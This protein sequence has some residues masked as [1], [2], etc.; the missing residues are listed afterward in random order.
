M[1][2]ASI[3][4]C[5][6]APHPAELLARWNLDPWL[7]LA[8]AVV[9]GAY[10]LGDGRRADRGQL[11]LFVSGW[12]MLVAIF[13]SPLCA[14][15]SA[16]FAA[17]VAHHVVLIGVA[18]PLLVLSLRPRSPLLPVGAAALLHAVV[19][20]FWHAPMPYTAA[21]GSDLLFWVM[22]L[23]LVASAWLFWQGV[24][25]ARSAPTA[26]LMALLGT[27]VQMGLLG[28]L[29][30]FAPAP[31]YPPHFL[32]TAPFGLSA[33]EDQQLAGLIMWVPSILPYLAVALALAARLLGSQAGAGG[34]RR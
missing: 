24:F 13:V 31:L 25:S 6:A 14:L 15:T 28:A 11:R 7:L 30:T 22:Q 12:V 19:V 10:A 2:Q 1:P 20:W 27:V 16:L 33:L 8:L 29:I 21:L 18:V 26:V 3:P 34:G 4:Y 32:T 17:R 9:A 5:G 23:S